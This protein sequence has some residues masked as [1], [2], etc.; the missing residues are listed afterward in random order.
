MRIIKVISIVALLTCLVYDT[1]P[2]IALDVMHDLVFLHY[3]LQSEGIE[4]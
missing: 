4:H 3:D 1:A 2:S